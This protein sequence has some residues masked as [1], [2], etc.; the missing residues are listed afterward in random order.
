MLFAPAVSIYLVLY[1]LLIT[2]E[3]NLTG[4]CELKEKIS[5]LS[6]HLNVGGIEKTICD[7][8]NMLSEKNIMLRLSHCIKMNNT[9]P[10]KLNKKMLK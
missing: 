4:R 3:L 5:I 1:L 9:I 10:F 6:L 7:Q 2:E 8:A